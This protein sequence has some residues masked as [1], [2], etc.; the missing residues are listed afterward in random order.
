MFTLAQLSYWSALHLGEA[1]LDSMKVRGRMQKGMVADIVIFDPK[2]VREGSSYKKGEQGLPPHGLPHVIVN[3]QFVKKDNKATD[4]FPGRP[5]RYPVEEKERFVPATTKQWL[6]TFTIDTS[7][8]KPKEKIE[9]KD[10]TSFRPGSSETHE[11]VAQLFGHVGAHSLGD[12][13]SCGSPLD[14]KSDDPYDPL[15]PVVIQETGLLS[16]LL[17]LKGRCHIS[18]GCNP[19]KQAVR[20]RCALKERLI[21]ALLQSGDGRTLQFPG[22][23]PG[24]I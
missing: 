15:S 3:G 8:I 22:L 16:S 4:V 13:L 11:Q 21:E 18:P 24:L 17:A 5:I 14:T 6:K 7:P 10:S 19:G 20:R 9:K 2:T 23:H 1:G 12:P